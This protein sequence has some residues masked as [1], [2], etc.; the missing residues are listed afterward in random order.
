MGEPENHRH[1]A[2]VAACVHASRVRRTERHA[3]FL[4]T[5][6]V[7][8]GSPWSIGNGRRMRRRCFCKVRRSRVSI[9]ADSELGAHIIDGLG[10]IE[11]AWG[12]DEDQF[13]MR[14]R[15]DHR[16]RVSGLFRRIYPRPSEKR[17]FMRRRK[18]FYARRIGH[19]T[20][21]PRGANKKRS[22]EPA[23]HRAGRVRRTG[24]LYCTTVGRLG[25]P[26]GLSARD[27]RGAICPRGNA[28]AHGLLSISGRAS[29]LE[30][31]EEDVHEKVPFMPRRGHRRARPTP[32]HLYEAG[33]VTKYRVARQGVPHGTPV[34]A[35]IAV[36][37]TPKSCPS[38]KSFRNTAADAIVHPAAELV[39]ADACGAHGSDIMFSS[40]ETPEEDF[41]SGISSSARRSIWTTSRI[42][43]CSKAL[44]ASLSTISCRYYPG[45]MFEAE[46]HHGQLGDANTQH[47][48]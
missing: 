44:S 12:C 2:V 41:K 37:A 16:A 29:C 1:M 14:E 43:T 28:V 26:G 24:G 23:G 30:V 45:G 32:F 9:R 3:C 42:S 40:N 36:K 4:A 33:I 38:S 11:V 7:R 47:D 35:S 27:R 48:G 46:R 5:G 25:M 6:K 15:I 19:D 39:L 8:P 18:F 10:Q 20:L 17:S 13:R 22:V 31:H 34:F 21:L